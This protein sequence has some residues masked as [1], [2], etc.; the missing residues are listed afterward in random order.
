MSTERP[1]PLHA[2]ARALAQRP[3]ASMEQ[4]AQAVGVSRATLHRMVS[5]RDE[6][7]NTLERFAY[8]ACARSFNEIN[9]QSGPTVEVLRKL[10]HELHPNSALFL[11]L[12]RHAYSHGYDRLTQNWSQQRARL[13]QF[14]R[15]GQDEGAFRVDVSAQWL[16][17]VFSALLQAAADATHEQRLA[18]AD[19]EHAITAVLL[20]GILRHPPSA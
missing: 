2:L 3:G 17:D 14:F 20:D 15:R 13:V 5:S 19:A 6:L 16:V 10:I 4:L 18:Q 11:F 8:D 1:I 9:L 12:Q 7:I